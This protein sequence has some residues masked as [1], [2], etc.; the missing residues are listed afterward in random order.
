ML[1]LSNDGRYPTSDA[2]PQ[3]R[4]Q[5]TLEAMSTQL[6]ALASQYPVLMIFDDVHWIDPTSSEALNRM[7]DRSGALPVLVVITFRPE[8]NA[9]WTGQPRVTSLT[10]SRL[11]EREARAIIAGLAG[12][13]ALTADLMAEI[14]QRTDGIPLF[15]EE[16]TKAVLEAESEDAAQ[17]TVAAALSSALSIPASL[18]ASLMARL[19]RL[20][21]AKEVAQIGAV[22][23]REF[24]YELISAVA[25]RGDDALRAGLDQL[26]DAGLVSQRGSLPEA[27]FLFKHA[28]VQ[29]AAY[30]TLLKGRRQHL[31]ARIAQMMEQRIPDKASTHPEL[32]A[33]HY[34]QAGFAEKAIEYW[35]KA[36]RLAVQRSMMAEAAVHFSKALQLLRTLP[37]S[38]RR[39]S[40]EI[41][42]QLDLAA[43]LMAV[44]GW[45][46]REAGEAYTHA[47]ELCGDVPEGPELAMALNGLRLILLNRADTRAARQVAMELLGLTARQN[48]SDAK[49]T[50]QYAYGV[51]LFFQAEFTGAV[52]QLREAIAI[53]DRS[54]NR[55][56]RSVPVDPRI[57]A[58][59]FGGWARVGAH[60]FAAC[61]LL[62]LGSS[63]QALALSREAVASARELG[64]PYTLAYSLH[65]N[66]VFHQLLGDAN[67]VWDRS[68]ELVAL[69]TKQSFP[70]LVGSGT[71]FRAWATMALGGSIQ[72]AISEMQQGLATKRATGA[73]IKVPYYYGLLAE[74]HV[75]TNRTTEGLDLLSE[76]LELVERTDERWY[77]AELYRLKGETL[78]KSA[79]RPGA[80]PWFS[81]ALAEARKQGAKFFELRAAASLARLWRD[82]GR[83]DE[84]RE[85]LAPVYGW[86]AEGFDTLDLKEA[87]KLLDELSS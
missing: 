32:T 61:A 17:Q 44:K 31:H 29:D 53:H 77:E 43:T 63:D 51:I 64:Y 38:S 13:R 27:T 35:E 26:V 76:A 11:G 85:L 71:F 41:G 79:D 84:A 74:A 36:G 12:N 40:G 67:T 4:R 82:Q 78:I 6:A 30:G 33:S 54:I 18:Q 86:F 39:R 34:A 70:H 48:D 10:L 3:Q 20:G 45:G 58:H 19:D 1:S 81:H 28:L 75:R 46:S 83:R 68:K 66:C 9:P 49:L 73:E 56:L 50:S 25:D 21:P 2:D 72:D 24:S 47:R 14:V 8:F 42:L 60:S 69:A 15:V 65:V 16:M 52:R 57:E 22:I 62:L 7:V 5:R 59:S 87:K 37:K 80:E 55:S 23:G